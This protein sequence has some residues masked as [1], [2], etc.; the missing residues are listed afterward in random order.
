MTKEESTWEGPAFRVGMEDLYIYQ[1]RKKELTRKQYEQLMQYLGETSPADWNYLGWLAYW[2]NH[3]STSLEFKHFMAISKEE[4][5]NI[6]RENMPTWFHGNNSPQREGGAIQQ[7][8]EEQEAPDLA[9]DLARRKAAFIKKFEQTN[10]YQEKG[11]IWSSTNQGLAVALK[12][13]ELLDVRESKGTKK[14]YLADVADKVFYNKNKKEYIKHKQLID[15]AKR[16]DIKF[17]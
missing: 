2:K 12:E 9:E 15:A 7:Q 10:W 13:S 11:Y 3:S 5:G 17:I 6:V 14:T 1:Q 8:T 4:F 16:C